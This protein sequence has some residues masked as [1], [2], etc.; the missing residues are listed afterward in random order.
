MTDLR[1]Y[2]TTFILN[3]DIDEND[4]NAVID[5]VRSIIE[6]F[7][8]EVL[9]VDDWGRRKLAYRVRKQNRG[10][11]IYV[12][13]TATGDAIAELERVLRILDA[14]LKYLTV[15]IDAQDEQEAVE[16]RA[17]RELRLSQQAGRNSVIE[18]DDDDQDDD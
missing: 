3:A 2:E 9:R 11:Y 15:K 1:H 18:D 5:R 17:R 4:K 12:R 10:L 6:S 8:G 16:A 14:V 7:S 13:Y